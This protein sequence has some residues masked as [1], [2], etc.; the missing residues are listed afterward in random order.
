MQLSICISW[1]K[2]AQYFG[3]NSVCYNI[4]EE[5]KLNFTKFSRYDTIY[6]I[7]CY[8]MLKRHSVSM[9]LFQSFSPS[10]RVFLLRKKISCFLFVLEMNYNQLVAFQ[11]QKMTSLMLMFLISNLWYVVASWDVVVS[12]IENWR[13]NFVCDYVC[14]VTAF[15]DYML[16]FCWNPIVRLYPFFQNTI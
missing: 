8:I 13:T 9:L 2:I 6:E 5:S 14:I 1:E 4:S 12:L 11:S 10:A 3:A 7:A 16:Y 15:L